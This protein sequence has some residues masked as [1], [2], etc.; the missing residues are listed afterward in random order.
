VESLEAQLGG[1]FIG[2]HPMAGSEQSGIQAARADLFDGAACIITPTP[3]SE[4]QALEAIRMFWKRTGCLLQEISPQ[5]HDRLIAQISHLPHA[6]AAALVNS[7]ASLGDLVSQLAGN[8]YRDTTRIAAGPADLWTEI[9]LGN[10]ANVVSAINEVS[11]SLDAL[12]AALEKNDR[13]AVEEFLT[14]A[15]ARRA[16]Q[17]KTP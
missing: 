5:E 9:L 2:A 17:R 1:R 12:R 10:R 8:G 4:P 16:T 15:S 6:L 7:S 13:P 3:R 14:L 11:R